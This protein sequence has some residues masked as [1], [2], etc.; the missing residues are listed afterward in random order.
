MLELG[1]VEVL[2]GWKRADAVVALGLTVDR[3]LIHTS[4]CAVGEEFVGERTN[5]VSSPSG[6]PERTDAVESMSAQFDV[7]VR[8][9]S[10]DALNLPRRH[11]EA[12]DRPT[13]DLLHENLRYFDGILC[14]CLDVKVFG[15]GTLV[16]SPRYR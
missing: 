15:T 7:D 8:E 14:F 9:L 6:Q 10:L 5:L 12:A 4:R 1:D 2:G 13:L 3:P 16:R 11:R